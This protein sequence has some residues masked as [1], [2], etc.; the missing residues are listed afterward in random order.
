MNTNM[1]VLT[2]FPTLHTP[3][4]ILR[5]LRMDD[6]DDLFEY[7]SH[8]EIDRYTPWSRYGSLD[9]ARA[10]LA[11]YVGQ[12]DGGNMP[13]WGVEHRTNQKLIGICDFNWHPQHRRAEIGYTI[14]PG[15]WGQGLAVEAVQAMILFGFAK[16]DLV[17]IEA[18]CVLD[19]R[20]SER[21]MQKVGM[22][23]EGVLHS[24]QIWRGTPQNLK[25]YAIVRLT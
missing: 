11:H 5:A 8:P 9:E 6:L 19:N 17:R 24:Y 2:P 25:M 3:R 23:F 13:V 15:Y 20:A 14:A 16:M 12:Y 18:V 10:D 22:Q 1:N 4:L 7:A 21:V